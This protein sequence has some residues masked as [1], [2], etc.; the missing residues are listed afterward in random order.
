[1]KRV[2][3]QDINAI[4]GDYAHEIDARALIVVLEG[5]TELTRA[6]S[7]VEDNQVV[8]LPGGF[9]GEVP[10]TFST[11]CPGKYPVSRAS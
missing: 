10:T 2:S 4:P 9:S 11:P 7:G 5:K 1:M 6:V 8:R 3:V